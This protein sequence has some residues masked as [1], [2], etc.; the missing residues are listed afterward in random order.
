MQES[1]NDDER[2]VSLW[3]LILGENQVDENC[4]L[5]NASEVDDMGDTENAETSVQLQVNERND[6]HV[7]QQIY[8]KG[9]LMLKE[10]NLGKLSGFVNGFDTKSGDHSVQWSDGVEKM[11]TENLIAELVVDSQDCDI[12]W[13]K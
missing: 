8:P 6:S 11:M 9:S 7:H 3:L 12:T 13:K 5:E 1:G 2:K 10:L 4:D